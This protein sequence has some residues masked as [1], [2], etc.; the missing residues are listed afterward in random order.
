[1]TLGD[2]GA[3]FHYRECAFKVLVDRFNVSWT[4]LDLLKN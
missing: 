1:M 4:R 2:I 3:L